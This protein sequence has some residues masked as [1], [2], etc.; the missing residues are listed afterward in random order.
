LET[1]SNSSRDFLRLATAASGVMLLVLDLAL[2]DCG[3][4]SG[5]EDQRRG[6]SIDIFWIA[7]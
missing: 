2:A 7:V 3:F 6:I 1:R 4:V 5:D